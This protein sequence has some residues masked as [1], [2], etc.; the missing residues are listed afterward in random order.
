MFGKETIVEKEVLTLAPVRWTLCPFLTD[1]GKCKARP[2]RVCRC[3][4]EPGRSWPRRCRLKDRDILVK[5][6]S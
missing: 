6:G 2:D 3:N 4:P 1:A 5:Q